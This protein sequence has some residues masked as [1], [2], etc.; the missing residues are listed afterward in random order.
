[1]SEKSPKGA[2]SAEKNEPEVPEFPLVEVTSLDILDA[3]CREAIF[4]EFTFSKR[5]WRVPG[6]LLTPAET[7]RVN[8]ILERALPDLMAGQAGADGET[9][10]DLR[11]PE[12]LTAKVKYKAQAQALAL[13]LAYPMFKENEKVKAVTVP[14]LKLELLTD[15]VQ[16]FFTDEIRQT[17][18]STAMGW[19]R[20]W[21]RVNFF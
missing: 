17:L 14:S 21:E 3:A 4:A 19:N 8:L 11:N 1:M 5:R 7:D 2:E 6:R 15:V 16:S 12:Y 20:L 13:F 9:R 18:W 10:Y